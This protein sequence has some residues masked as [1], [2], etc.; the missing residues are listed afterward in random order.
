M[1]SVQ[2][3]D[4]YLLEIKLSTSDLDGFVKRVILMGVGTRGS[5]SL[6]ASFNRECR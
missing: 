6:N 1:G 4:H 2:L 3:S 5:G